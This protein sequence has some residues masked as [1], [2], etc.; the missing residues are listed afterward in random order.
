MAAEY[1]N[2]PCDD[3]TDLLAEWYRQWRDRDD[4]PPKM[5]DSLHVRTMIALLAAGRINPETAELFAPNEQSA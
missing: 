4:M 1:A 2:I 5:D 3:A